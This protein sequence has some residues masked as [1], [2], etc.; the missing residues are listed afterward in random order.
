[1]RFAMVGSSFPE[2]CCD[3]HPVFGTLLANN[4]ELTRDERRRALTIYQGIHYSSVGS[5]EEEEAT[6]TKGTTRIV[7]QQ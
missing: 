6:C 3:V 5:E 2:D 7:L 1:M 4:G